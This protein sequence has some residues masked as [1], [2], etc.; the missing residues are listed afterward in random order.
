MKEAVE[1]RL[2][3]LEQE[4]ERAK[5]HVNAVVGALAVLKDLLAPEP[6]PKDDDGTPA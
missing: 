1:R 3:E 4:L 2:A 5:A 6:Q